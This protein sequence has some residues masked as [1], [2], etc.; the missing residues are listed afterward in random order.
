MSILIKRI[1][2]IGVVVNSLTASG[3]KLHEILGARGG[4]VLKAQEYGMVA[5]MFRIGNI[6]FELMQPANQ[7]GLI[8]QFL[9]KRGEGLHHIA[10]EVEDI[11]DSINWIKR[12]NG[13]IINEQPVSVDDLKAAFLHPGSFGGVLIELIEGTPKHVDNRPLPRELQTRAQAEGVGSEGIL[14][15][16]ILVKD[17][18]SASSIYS[19]I[20]L[21][22]AS[23]I[24][25]SEQYSV[26]MRVCRTENV[27]LKL[28]EMNKVHGYSNALFGQNQ[29]GLNH[30]TLKVKNIQKAIAYLQQK[31]VSFDEEPLA[32]FYNSRYVFIHPE[33][34]SGIPILLKE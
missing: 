12:N 4:T 5:Q 18:E 10:F 28:L 11:N 8:A 27:N 31:G 33:E 1:T 29:I 22:E 26:R 7:D 17:I 21:S 15:V 14:E 19:K 20:F 23:E 3:D 6:E 9:E 30:V 25:D 2:E 34:L 16:G 13:R 24:E 32:N